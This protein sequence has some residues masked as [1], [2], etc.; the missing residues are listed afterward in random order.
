LNARL[1]VVSPDETK[2]DT[3][4]G[5]LSVTACANPHTAS[6][7]VSFEATLT[8]ASNHGRPDQRK[9]ISGTSAEDFDGLSATFVSAGPCS[10]SPSRDKTVCITYTSNG[11]GL[12]TELTITALGKSASDRET[13]DLSAT[14]PVDAGGANVRVPYTVTVTDLSGNDRPKWTYSDATTSAENFP[15]LTISLVSFGPESSKPSYNKRVCA[16]FTADGKGAD[17]KLTI[18]TDSPA[19]SVSATGTGKISPDPFCVDAGSA[20]KTVTFTA[21]VTDND[22]NERMQKFL[23]QPVTS[24][25]DPPEMQLWVDSFT[26]DPPGESTDKQVCATFRA[27]GAENSDDYPVKLV[28]TNSRTSKQS[29]W[30]GTRFITEPLCVDAGGP[31]VTVTF[32]GTLTDLSG[33]GRSIEPKSVDVVS[34]ADPPSCTFH[35]T[36]AHDVTIWYDRMP[37]DAQMWYIYHYSDHD[38][39]RCYTTDGSTATPC[40][41][42]V[43]AGS[44]RITNWLSSADLTKDSIDFSMRY[45]KTAYIAYCTK[46]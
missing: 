16:T 32:T 28:V 11:N 31:S 9:T 41:T 8:D 12:D 21:T 20:S 34:P 22:N 36:S 13:G 2:S 19:Y 42:Y 46:V 26:P 3:K 7:S 24:P 23:A 25:A 17:A 27:E 10:G 29:S 39:N 15:D 35:I 5:A 37:K 45:N 18:T 4:S 14:L 44:E 33:A 1:E 40:R 6:A 43:D 38:S 30:Q